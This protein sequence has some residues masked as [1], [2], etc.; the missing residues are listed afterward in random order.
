MRISS[1]VDENNALQKIVTYDFAEKNMRRDPWGGKE[2]GIRQHY[3]RCI[4]PEHVPDDFVVAEAGQSGRL[5]GTLVQ[6]CL[7]G[8]ASNGAATCLTDTAT[9]KCSSCFKMA[10][11]EAQGS[12]INYYPR[13]QVCAIQCCCCEWSSRC[14]A[15]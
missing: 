2:N 3:S 12:R 15:F 1:V 9:P 8:T 4:P 5:I 7:R 13:S 10:T 14:R 11:L 6:Q